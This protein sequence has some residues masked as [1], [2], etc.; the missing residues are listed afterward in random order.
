VQSVEEFPFSNA[1]VKS[2]VKIR[3]EKLNG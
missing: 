1:K 2:S 3:F